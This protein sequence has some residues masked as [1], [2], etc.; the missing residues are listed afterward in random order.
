MEEPVSKADARFKEAVLF[1]KKFRAA[2]INNGIPENKAQWYEHWARQFSLSVPKIPLVNRNEAQVTDFLRNLEA[3]QNIED[4]QFKQAVEALKILYY[5]VFGYEWAK[6]LTNQGLG[7]RKIDKPGEFLEP[8]AEPPQTATETARVFPEELAPIISNQLE[9]KDIYS[10]IRDEL[11]KSHYSLSTE[12][13]YLNWIRRFLSFQNKSLSEL[14][15][16]AVDEYF[17]HLGAEKPVSASTR[18]QAMNALVFF[19]EKVLKEPLV[20]VDSL[21]ADKQEQKK[22]Q[23][24]SEEDISSLLGGLSQVHSLVAGLIYSCR[25][26]LMECLRL[27]VQDIDFEREEIAV[28][29]SRGQKKRIVSLPEQHHVQLQEHLVNVRHQHEADLA[30]G[31]GEVYL[32]PAFVK[33]YPDAVREWGWQYVF[34]SNRLTVDQNTK[35]V[36]RHHIHPTAIQNALRGAARETGL[37]SHV[38]CQI[39]RHS[40]KK[41]DKSF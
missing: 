6:T 32:W 26:R 41:K 18:N 29:D 4:W 25:L 7:K 38:T 10:T 22:P 17:M 9:K 27:R 20:A 39:L 28:R 36:R 34:P 3:K 31:L 12:K 1:W 19:Y 15:Q 14:T 37:S 24:V 40:S 16:G 35:K 13:L 5:D 8:Q 2:V 30:E 21:P 33:K 23:N 11:R